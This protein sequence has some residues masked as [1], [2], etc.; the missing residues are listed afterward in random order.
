MITTMVGI[1]VL[2]VDVV[3]EKVIWILTI[4]FLKVKAAVTVFIIFSV[5]ASIAIAQKE[6]LLIR[7]K[8]ASLRDTPKDLFGATK[9]KVKS[10]YNN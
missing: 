6:I 9:R 3:S 2:S 10:Y 4:L 7:S 8:Q 5:C 1:N